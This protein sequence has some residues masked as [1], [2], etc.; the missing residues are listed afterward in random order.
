[1][2]RNIK[3]EI[4]REQFLEAIEL[5]NRY[6]KQ[7]E[8]DIESLSHKKGGVIDF[9]ILD[10]NTN[11]IDV[12]GIS[13]RLLN[14]LKSNEIDGKLSNLR[15]VS[16]KEFRQYRNVGP[17]TLRELIELCVAAGVMPRP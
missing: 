6:K 5:I 9:G 16:L 14:T 2:E 11:I 15:N 17:S 10:P 4:T 13:V 1:M 3:D 12:D 7:I 8:Q